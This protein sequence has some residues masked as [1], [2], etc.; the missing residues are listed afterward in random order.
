M[1]YVEGTINS[2]R[3]HWFGLLDMDFSQCWERTKARDTDQVYLQNG[4][5]LQA[6]ESRLQMLHT[7]TRDLPIQWQETRYSL[8][9]EM[10][11][12]TNG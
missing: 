3:S 6:L 4:P 8:S 2:R 12:G 11:G 9:K 7:E 10:V 1:I 5:S